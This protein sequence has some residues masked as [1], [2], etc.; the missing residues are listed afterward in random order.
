MFY[1]DIIESSKQ[2]WSQRKHLTLQLKA[3]RKYHWQL[4]SLLQTAKLAMPCNSV[5][6]E[7]L[8]KI[9]ERFTMAIF[10]CTLCQRNNFTNAFNLPRMLKRPTHFPWYHWE[11]VSQ[12]IMNL[13][14]KINEN[15]IH[16]KNNESNEEQMLWRASRRI[17]T[18]T[19]L[20]TGHMDIFQDSW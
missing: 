19:S 7:T 9:E 18:M 12:L 15:S 13:K 14:I 1:F 20:D 8:E 3:S 16:G 10:R 6:V 5:P 2:T 11:H 17:H 4:F